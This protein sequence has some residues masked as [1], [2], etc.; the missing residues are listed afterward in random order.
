MW[1]QYTSSS[2][3]DNVDAT[4]AVDMLGLAALT[5][6]LPGKRIAAISLPMRFRVVDDGIAC[7]RKKMVV[8]LL[9]TLLGPG[10]YTKPSAAQMLRFCRGMHAV[11]ILHMDIKPDN[12]LLSAPSGATPANSE[13]QALRRKVHSLSLIDFGGAID[14]SVF[15][16]NGSRIE[17]RDHCCAPSFSC[18]AMMEVRD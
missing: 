1:L 12:W 17:F 15:P 9:Y 6:T 13:D 5:A 18:P 3:C 11:C 16:Q 7:F 14:L 8:P 10:A 4:C 2:A